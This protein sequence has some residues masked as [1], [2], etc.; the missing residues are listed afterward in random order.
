MRVAVVVLGVEADELEQLLH[1]RL[2][3]AGR[4]TFCSRNGAPTIAPT[5]CRG[6]SEEYGSWKII[7][8]SRRS[9]RICPA[10][11]G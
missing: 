4:L 6:L 8:I 9:G 7:W 11:G 5:V 2:D 10:A 3:P 1:G